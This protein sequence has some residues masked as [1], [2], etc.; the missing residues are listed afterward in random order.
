MGCDNVN[1][2]LYDDES[3]NC[4]FSSGF[5]E[6]TVH[7]LKLFKY[8]KIATSLFQ[9]I[10]SHSQPSMSFMQGPGAISFSCP[11]TS[12]ITLWMSPWDAGW[13]ITVWM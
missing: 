5:S 3:P 2:R 13:L 7:L 8:L 11:V 1:C 10:L 6:L 9:L 12:F 4:V